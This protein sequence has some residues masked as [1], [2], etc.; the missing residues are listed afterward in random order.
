[1]AKAA[2]Q[3]RS[4]AKLFALPLAP[5]PAD[6]DS[7]EALDAA[8][9]LLTEARRG[10]VQGLMV[11]VLDGQGNYYTDVFGR[12]KRAATLARGAL[13]ALDDDLAAIVRAEKGQP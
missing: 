9:H 3:Q 11:V 4:T 2:A 10:N 5:T 8:Q 6:T 12:F 1:M 7:C 13:R